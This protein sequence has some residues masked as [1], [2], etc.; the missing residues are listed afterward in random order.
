MTKR[1]C[2]GKIAAP[3]G[4]KGLVKILPYGSNPSLIQDLSPAYTSE[5]GSDTLAITLK[6]PSGKYILAAIQ[7]C[8]TR[9][10]SDELRGT[11][12]YY[13][14][15]KL[16]EPDEGEIY[17]DALVGLTAFEDGQEHG[18]IIAVQN[19]GASDL[20]E[21]KP[22]GGASYFLPFTEDYV[23]D[24]N[25]DESTIEIFNSKDITDL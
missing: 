16:P 25:L 15:D 19:F 11:E 8:T 10:G 18:K 1:V 21:I 9:E 7:G 14:A 17:Y 20:L 24:I 2:L 3:H 5:N 22:K 12:L 4:V 23:G 13:D 6:N